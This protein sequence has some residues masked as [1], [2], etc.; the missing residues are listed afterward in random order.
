MTAKTVYMHRTPL[1]AVLLIVQYGSQT[2]SSPQTETAWLDI[3]QR[4][5]VIYS[6]IDVEAI[7]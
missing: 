1:N 7:H 4:T 3:R 5:N 2:E 6:L